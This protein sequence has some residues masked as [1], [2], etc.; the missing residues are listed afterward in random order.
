MMAVP[1][2]VP[3]NIINVVFVIRSQ[4]KGTKLSFTFILDSSFLKWTFFSLTRLI[5]GIVFVL[6]RVKLTWVKYRIKIWEKLLRVS[7]KL[8]L[9][10]RV[11]GVRVD[12]LV[13]N[14]RYQL[15]IV[16]LKGSN[17]QHCWSVLSVA[18]LYSLGNFL[19]FD[20]MLHILLR[21]L[22]RLVFK[23]QVFLYIF[24]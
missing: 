12:I 19:S 11:Q 3:Y 1:I 2:F 8:R 15:L 17:V 23:L 10:V 5:V 14:P 21:W 13:L 4:T 9:A 18:K 6:T 7:N 22:D 24:N 16:L 20:V